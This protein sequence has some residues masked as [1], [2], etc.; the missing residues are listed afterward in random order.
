MLKDL[1]LQVPLQDK[2]LSYITMPNH[3]MRYFHSKSQQNP[4]TDAGQVW[5]GDIPMEVKAGMA[6]YTKSIKE[7]LANGEYYVYQKLLFYWSPK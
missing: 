3:F 1:G 5:E 7:N 4:E 2:G 6:H